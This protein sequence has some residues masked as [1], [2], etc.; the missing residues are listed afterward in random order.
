MKVRAG[1]PEERTRLGAREHDGIDLHTLRRV[2]EA[3]HERGDG[4]VADEP[5]DQE[6]V[7]AA[8]EHRLY[9]LD[10]F[11]RAAQSP[12]GEESADLRADP[13]DRRVRILERGP[14]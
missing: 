4:S 6:R 8:V 2:A 14:E 12:G 3:H 7:P 11:G 5:P 13:V 10:G 1:V 9:Q